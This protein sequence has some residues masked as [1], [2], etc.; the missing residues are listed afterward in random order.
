MS[1]LGAAV[2]TLP[3]GDPVNVSRRRFIAG[4]A[5]GALVLGFGMPLGRAR[6]QGATIAPGTRVPAFLEIRPD[7][8]IRC[9]ARSPRAG[10]ASGRR[11]RK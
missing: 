5:A 3:L 10:K 2:G 7:S 9:S 6:G 8:S 11:W 4:T 1:D